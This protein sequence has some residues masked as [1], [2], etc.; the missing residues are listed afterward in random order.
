VEP[1]DINSSIRAAGFRRARQRIVALASAPELVSK[2][3]AAAD[4]PNLAREIAVPQAFP[5]AP[6]GAIVVWMFVQNSQVMHK[7]TSTEI[8]I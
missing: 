4:A 3:W 7:I 5:L 1:Q 2:T 6:Q 8:I